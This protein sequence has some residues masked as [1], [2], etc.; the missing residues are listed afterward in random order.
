WERI[1]FHIHPNR[2]RAA[3]H[4]VKSIDTSGIGRHVPGGNIFYWHGKLIV[5]KRDGLLR[6]PDNVTPDILIVANNS[7]HVRDIKKIRSSSGLIILDSSNSYFYVS[8][9]LKEAAAAGLRVHSVKH[10][11]AYEEYVSNSI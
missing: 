11:G 7:L 8:Q 4:N 1:R 9:F 6:I 3:V 10:N 5:Y 2:L